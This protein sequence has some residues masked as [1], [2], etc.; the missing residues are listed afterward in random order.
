GCHTLR[1]FSVTHITRIHSGI[2]KSSRC[3]L[4]PA[5]A[6]RCHTQHPMSAHCSPRVSMLVPMRRITMLLAYR[7]RPGPIPV[8]PMAA[9]TIVSRLRSYLTVLDPE[10]GVS[11]TRITARGPNI[12]QGMF[13]FFE[14]PASGERLLTDTK[15]EFLEVLHQAVPDPAVAAPV[16]PVTMDGRT[17]ALALTC[18]EEPGPLA[19]AP[20]LVSRVKGDLPLVTSDISLEP[21]NPVLVGAAA[22]APLAVAFNAPDSCGGPGVAGIPGAGRVPI[23]TEQHL[24]DVIEGEDGHVLQARH[25]IGNA[26]HGRQGLVVGEGHPGRDERVICL[27]GMH[28]QMPETHPA[29]FQNL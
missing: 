3:I 19:A 1:A 8:I 20:L 27:Q 10:K 28:I 11:D 29:H 23:V 26:L 5:F 7:S 2:W 22:V 9:L 15:K 18:V 17:R 25:E 24:N 6:Y 4:P 16:A 12:E 13:E 14:I 21:V